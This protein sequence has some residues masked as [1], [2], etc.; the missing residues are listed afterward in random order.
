MRYHSRHLASLLTAVVFFGLLGI[1]GCA[2][3][4]SVRVYDP[5]YHDYHRWNRTEIVYYQQWERD[6][7]RQDEDFDRRSPE[8]QREYWQ[9]RHKH[10]DHD[11]DRN[12]H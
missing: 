6:T 10:H 11:H 4:G 1:T 2:A 9:W 3:R 7:H 12:N 8:D 5:E